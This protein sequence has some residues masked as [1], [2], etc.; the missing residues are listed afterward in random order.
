MLMEGFSVMI[1]SK[2]QILQDFVLTFWFHYI[3]TALLEPNIRYKHLCFNKS[4]FL[5]S[6]VQD[7]CDINYCIDVCRYKHL[8]YACAQSQE[9]IVICSHLIIF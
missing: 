7:Y 2:K 1:Y 6:N 3:F 4:Q 9:V 5:K 8:S